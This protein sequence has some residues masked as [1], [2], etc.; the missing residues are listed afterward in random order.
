MK[1]DHELGLKVHEQLKYLGVETPM[2][3]DKVNASKSEKIEVL[4]KLFGEIWET[5]GLDLHDD[6][7]KETPGRMAKMYVNEIY[8]G[9][10]YCMFPKC[11]TVDNKMSYD[12][13][14]M[15]RPISVQS[16]C[17]HHGVVI[18]GKACVAYIPGEKILG[19]SKINRVV[20][21]FSKRPQIQERLTAQIY[22][23]LV[24]ILGTANVAVVIEAEHY[25]VKSRGV[26]DEAS[27]TVTSKLGGLFRQPALR[28]EFMSLATA[29][30]NKG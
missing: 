11:T 4:T 23:S 19:L 25:C 22:H 20:E 14:I 21:F 13:M 5:V 15:E 30:L 28:A 6:S 3:L 18:A 16:N 9:L 12:E 26:R 2:I 7:L 1:T 10:D 17:E 27:Q 8:Y 24:L 29:H